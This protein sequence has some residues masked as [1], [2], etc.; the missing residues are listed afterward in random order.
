[1]GAAD[2]LRRLN[3][4]LAERRGSLSPN[5]TLVSLDAYQAAIWVARVLLPLPP[6]RFITAMIGMRRLGYGAWL[7]GKLPV[8][9]VVRSP[10]LED[11]LDC[12]Q[13]EMVKIS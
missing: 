6:L 13:L 5:M 11:G 8:A 10:L 9:G 4:L 2:L 7:A 3:Q 12:H 1:M